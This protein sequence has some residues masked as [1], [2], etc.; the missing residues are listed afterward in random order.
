MMRG[1]VVEKFTIKLFN[2]LKNLLLLQ[3]NSELW[4]QE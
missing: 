2:T 4:Y 3:K 1:N